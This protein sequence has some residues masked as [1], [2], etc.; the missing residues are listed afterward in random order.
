MQ[1]ISNTYVT[2]QAMPP[3]GLG[4]Q[5]TF[6]SAFAFCVIVFDKKWARF[7]FNHGLNTIQ[8]AVLR[9]P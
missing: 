4:N 3:W 6:A 2:Y 5:Y 9:T 7:Y 1:L 8:Y